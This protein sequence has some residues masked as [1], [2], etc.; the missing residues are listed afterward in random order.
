MGNQLNINTNLKLKKM[1][2][3]IFKLTISILSILMIIVLLNNCSSG[4]KKKQFDDYESLAKAFKG[5]SYNNVKKE[6]GEPS[7]KFYSVSREEITYSWR[8]V[9]VKGR[10]DAYLNFE[11]MEYAPGFVKGYVFK[12]VQSS[13]YT[14]PPSNDG[15]PIYID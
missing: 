15:N 7:Y 5:V 4:W 8:G 1:K 2:N 11:A 13:E 10:P 9:G 6:F 14:H 12:T 3:K